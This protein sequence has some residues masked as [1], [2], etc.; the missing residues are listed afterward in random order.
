MHLVSMVITS[1]QMWRNVVWSWWAGENQWELSWVRNTSDLHASFPVWLF[2]LMMKLMLR[3]GN[4]LMSIPHHRD[5]QPLVTLYTGRSFVSPTNSLGTR[6][7]LWRNVYTLWLIITVEFW[8][9]GFLYTWLARE[10]Y[11]VLHSPVVLISLPHLLPSSF[12]P[13]S[14]S[15]SFSPPPFSSIR[16]SPTLT[17][18]LF[19]CIYIV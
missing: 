2:Q 19:D 5:S 7:S 6:L 8:Y 15:S 13:P 16:L 12:L 3:H 17:P 14:P 18:V 9:L 4:C 10:I 11:L 1:W